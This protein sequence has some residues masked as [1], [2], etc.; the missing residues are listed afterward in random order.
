[1]GGGVPFSNKVLD[2][3]KEDSF[4]FFINFVLFFTEII[5]FFTKFLGEK[6]TNI[7]AKKHEMKH[8]HTLIIKLYTF[9]V[10]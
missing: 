1:M 8:K 7:L 6:F 4:I 3:F 2:I 9:V 10:L 5:R